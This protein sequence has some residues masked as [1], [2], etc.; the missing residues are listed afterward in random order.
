MA[1][2]EECRAA[3]ENL[4]ARLASVDEGMRRK[5]SLDRSLSCR[6][7]DLG[8]AFSG[9]LVDGTLRGL[10][11]VPNPAAKIKIA[12]S[13]DDLVA[14]TRGSLSFTKAWADGRLKVD[15]SVLDLLKLRSLA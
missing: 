4:A 15:A 1:T 8:V 6:V 9:R 12:T 14:L 7:T 5:H 3:L 2:V 10:E 13:S 11:Q